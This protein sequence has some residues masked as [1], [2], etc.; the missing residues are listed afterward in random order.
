M[1][2]QAMHT[3]VRDQGPHNPAEIVVFGVYIGHHKQASGTQATNSA[4][5]QRG[6]EGGGRQS[7]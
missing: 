7:L 4:L 5:K 2:A 6:G 1:Y 3:R